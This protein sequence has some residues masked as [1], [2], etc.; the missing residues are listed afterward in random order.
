MAICLPGRAS[1]VKRAATSA[2][3]SAPFATTRSWTSVMM[4]KTT[5]PTT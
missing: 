5:A 2:T 3:R 1:S 4:A